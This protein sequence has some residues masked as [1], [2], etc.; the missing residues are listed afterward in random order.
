MG[1]KKRMLRGVAI[2]QITVGAVMFILGC[3]N[4]NTYKN[5]RVY[6]EGDVQDNTREIAAESAIG[7][8]G[9]IWMIASGTIGVI[10]STRP[11]KPMVIVNFSLSIIASVVAFAALTLYAVVLKERYEVNGCHDYKFLISRER[12]YMDDCHSGLALNAVL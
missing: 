2:A 10:C 3:V 1:I 8:W 12:K 9:G 5:R 6:R 7:I 11:N 4:Q